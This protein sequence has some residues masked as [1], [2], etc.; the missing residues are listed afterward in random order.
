MKLVFSL[1]PFLFDLCHSVSGRN[2]LNVSLFYGG[3]SKTDAS[4][5]LSLRLFF[6][7][8]L[9]RLKPSADWFQAK[10]LNEAELR[11][12]PRVWEGQVRFKSRRQ[13][14]VNPALETL[15]CVRQDDVCVTC[16][17]GDARVR[18]LRCFPEEGLQL[19]ARTE[20]KCV[21]VKKGDGFRLAMTRVTNEYHEL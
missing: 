20:G 4:A 14:P 9:H 16:S 8:H 11:V 7:F 13:R 10:P 12:L 15:R 3:R 17:S 18:P 19:G 2:P 5:Q 1:I 21:P 6:I